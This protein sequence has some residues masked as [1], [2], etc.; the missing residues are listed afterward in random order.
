MS[1]GFC[2]SCG[3]VLE[4]GVPCPKAC[5]APIFVV[6]D[7]THR[8]KV[9]DALWHQWPDSR[10]SLV[11]RDCGPCCDNAPMGEQ[12]EAL[13]PPEVGYGAPS[14]SLRLVPAL[15]LDAPPINH[16]AEGVLTMSEPVAVPVVSPTGQP[17]LPNWVPAVAATLVTVAAGLQQVLPPHTLGFQIAGVVVALGAAFGIVSQG[18]RKRV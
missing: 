14:P 11:S 4:Q 8:C 18:A 5:G 16:P 6:P 12:I 15:A 7:A 1:A 9:C 13:E 2:G 10:W 3:A 17:V